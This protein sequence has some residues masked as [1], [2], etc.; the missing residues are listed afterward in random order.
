MMMDIQ[1]RIFKLILP[2]S[3]W[4]RFR[5]DYLR[6]MRGK[7]LPTHVYSPWHMWDLMD[8]WNYMDKR[9]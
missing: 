9:S 8:E 3:M 5:L 6:Y 4:K 7:L 1:T 2:D